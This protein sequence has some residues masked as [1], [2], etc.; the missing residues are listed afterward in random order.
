TLTPADYKRWETIGTGELSPDGRWVV[1]TIR[2]V[3]ADGELRYRDVQ[4]NTERVVAYATNP[5][6]SADGRWLAYNIGHSEKEM[7]AATKS[8]TTLHGKLGLVDLRSG[9]TTIV[10][11]IATF[12]FNADGRF[13]A[14]KGYAAKDQKHKGVPLIVR[15]L[16]T[17]RQTTL[18]N[19]AEHA[20]QDETGSLLAITIDTETKVGNGV[21]VYDAAT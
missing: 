18:G 8:K 20:W 2:R 7:E 17:G 3:D 1:Y 13:L 4:T 19:V 6:F 11:D 16:A 21:Q 10:D 5:A 15:D 9:E 14:M 12:E